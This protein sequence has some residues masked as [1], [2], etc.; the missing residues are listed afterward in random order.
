MWR[1]SGELVFGSHSFGVKIFD[2]EKD[3]ETNEENI[4][5]WTS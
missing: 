1:L 3:C 2:E 4:P 5:I